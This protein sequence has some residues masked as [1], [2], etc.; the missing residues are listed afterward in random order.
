N[1]QIGN[2]HWTIHR[3]F[4]DFKNVHGLL[5]HTHSSE[6]LAGVKLP[7]QRIFKR[8]KFDP[9]YL[10]ERCEQ[11]D[12]YIHKLLDVPSLAADPVVMDFLSNNWRQPKRPKKNPI[13][14]RDMK[15][16]P[17]DLTNRKNANGGI[18]PGMTPKEI[19]RIIA[20]QNKQ[21]LGRGRSDKRKFIRNG[22][23][24][25]SLGGTSSGPA[26]KAEEKGD[27]QAEEP[28][29]TLGQQG[30]PFDTGFARVFNTKMTKNNSG[31]GNRKRKPGAPL[32]RKARLPPL[33]AIDMVPPIA[34]VDCAPKCLD[35][36]KQL[37]VEYKGTM[38]L[39]GTP[40]MDRVGLDGYGVGGEEDEERQSASKTNMYADTD[41][42]GQ[43]TD[44]GA[45]SDTN[46]RTFHSE[47]Q[48]NREI[49]TSGDESFGETL[50]TRAMD[51][52]AKESVAQDG[53]RPSPMYP[54][55]PEDRMPPGSVVEDVVEGL[56]MGAASD[57]DIPHRHSPLIHEEQ[58]SE[59][60]RA[61]GQHG[62]HTLRQKKQLGVHQDANHAGASRGNNKGGH[63]LQQSER[64]K[65]QQQQLLEAG[66]PANAYGEG[67]SE[68]G[69]LVAEMDLN[70]PT[71]KLVSRQRSLTA[72]RSGALGPSQQRQP[73]TAEV[74]HKKPLITAKGTS[75][76]AKRPPLASR[77]STWFSNALSLNEDEDLGDSELLSDEKSAA[78]SGGSVP[79]SGGTDE[80][81][82]VKTAGPFTHQQLLKMHQQQQRQQMKDKRQN[83]RRSPHAYNQKRVPTLL[84]PSSST[85]LSVGSPTNRQSAQQQHRQQVQL[86]H[87]V[88]QLHHKQQQQ[89]EQQQE[90]QQQQQQ[91]TLDHQQPHDLPQGTATQQQPWD[92]R[93]AKQD[94]P[95]AQRDRSRSRDE[96]DSA[97]PR[98]ETTASSESD[99]EGVE[100]SALHKS[101]SVGKAATDTFQPTHRRAPS[102][103]T[104]DAHSSESATRRSIAT[105]SARAANNARAGA[106]GSDIEFEIP[107]AHLV[108]RLEDRRGSISS[109]SAV[110]AIASAV[111]AGINSIFSSGVSTIM[112]GAKGVQDADPDHMSEDPLH[113]GIYSDRP[114]ELCAPNSDSALPYADNSAWSFTRVNS[115][116]LS[117]SPPARQASASITIEPRASTMASSAARHRSEAGSSAERF[118]PTSPKY[119]PINHASTHMHASSPL[120]QMSMLRNRIVLPTTETVSDGTDGESESSVTS[121][122]S[123]AISRQASTNSA[124]GSPRSRELEKHHNM[125]AQQQLLLKSYSRLRFNRAPSSPPKAHTSPMQRHISASTAT[126][127]T[128]HSMDTSRVLI[129]SATSP[130]RLR[131]ASESSGGMGLFNDHSVGDVG[132]ELR[133][134]QSYNEAE[135]QESDTER[136]AV[137]DELQTENTLGTSASV[138]SLTDANVAN[139]F[140]TASG[141]VYPADSVT[142]GRTASESM[143]HS[144]SSSSRDG[145]ILV[146]EA[147]LEQAREVSRSGSFPTN[148]SSESESDNSALS[149]PTEPGRSPSPEPSSL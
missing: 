12:E 25:V 124:T 116:P 44:S 79:A 90:L 85:G 123:R 34:V 10:Y 76:P 31:G 93:Q 66:Q 99:E 84:L 133:K 87:Q 88:Q 69:V 142:A 4:N 148:T 2:R 81:P 30:V 33:G 103:T 98:S 56:A 36:Q 39:L 23:G 119:S 18:Q 111:S 149:T 1:V 143:D 49:D 32:T 8:K 92:T 38:L 140:E 109:D 15:A 53:L 113:T 96:D 52:A 65:K 128:D 104:T 100:S 5:G 102:N 42:S 59:V 136:S 62:T 19:K 60:P 43:S 108:G 40:N 41:T 50:S 68:Q 144:L 97:A 122:S 145:D 141:G 46:L 7:P 146:F 75:V 51:L 55:Q 114:K 129:R 131:I 107:D 110:N 47:P 125:I 137:T 9:A 130:R 54:S 82:S 94:Q 61:H 13:P 20:R 115:V 45:S 101:E 80:G 58:V 135:V 127:N 3:R 14:G 27:G 73:G 112:R 71:K 63:K 16:G 72:R 22:P 78:E 28:Y 105:D 6:E 89:H 37:A 48:G 138:D 77:L 147:L 134:F 57:G 17:I 117:G 64:K 95:P 24:V 74:L 70:F 118:S 139:V 132:V 120:P 106:R 67:V 29:S 126:I 26:V 83:T 21:Q 86:H 11:L 91:K 35:L 121:N